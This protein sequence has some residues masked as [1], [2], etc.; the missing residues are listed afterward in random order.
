MTK[1]VEV[2]Q[3]DAPFDSF[4]LSTVGKFK[5]ARRRRTVR[6]NKQISF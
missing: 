3:K 5:V 6:P 2:R 4:Q 1:G